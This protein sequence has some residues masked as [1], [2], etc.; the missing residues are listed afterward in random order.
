MIHESLLTPKTRVRPLSSVNSYM[1]LKVSFVRETLSTLR[2]DEWLLSSVNSYAILKVCF[3]C[4]VLSTVIAHERLLSS[5]SFYMILK[6]FA[7]FE[8]VHSCVNPNVIFKVFKSDSMI[9]HVDSKVFLCV[10]L[11][12][13]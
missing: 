6:A 3:V 13:H 11:F 10:K 5:A 4:A 7:V 8:T 1:N 12:S 2:A 9:W